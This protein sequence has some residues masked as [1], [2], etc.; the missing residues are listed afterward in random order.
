MT[1]EMEIQEPMEKRVK[2]GNTE[3]LER[4]ALLGSLDYLASQDIKELQVNREAEDQREDQDLRE[5]LGVRERW[6]T[7]ATWVSRDQ[8]ALTVRWDLL[9]FE[10]YRVAEDTRARR[11][12]VGNLVCRDQRE[13]VAI[14]A[15]GVLLDHMVPKVIRDLRGLM[16]YQGRRETW[17]NQDIRDR[18]ESPDRVV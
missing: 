5:P 9:D 2:E 3:P 4:K 10:V 12:R 13:S 11:V 17:V 1:D 7:L 14:S 16:D 15:R 6:G 18:R 8:E